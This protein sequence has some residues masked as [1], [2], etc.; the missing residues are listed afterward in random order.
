MIYIVG[1]VSFC[2]ATSTFYKKLNIY[3]FQLLCCCV[4]FA[5]MSLLT[6]FKNTAEE[7]HYDNSLIIVY[8]FL[9]YNYNLFYNQDFTINRYTFSEF[10][11]NG[12]SLLY[13]TGNY[14]LTFYHQII[15]VIVLFKV[16]IQMLNFEKFFRPALHVLILNIC[17]L[18]LQNPH[19]WITL[20]MLPFV[21]PIVVDDDSFGLN[22]IGHA[23]YKLLEDNNVKKVV[24]ICDVI[25]DAES[26]KTI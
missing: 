14:S 25:T 21:Y 5:A 6:K 18:H 15:F 16:M 8:I 24:M 2:V 13:I 10:L 17:L 26:K 19:A 22:D 12:F 7:L 9:Y 20:M 23:A 11:F 1:A 4:P 3:P